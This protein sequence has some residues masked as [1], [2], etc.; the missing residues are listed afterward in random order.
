LVFNPDNDAKWAA[1][2]TSIGV[3]PTLLSGQV[4]RA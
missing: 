2:L 3:D 4:G 1:A